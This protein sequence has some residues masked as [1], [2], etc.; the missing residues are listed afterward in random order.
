MLKNKMKNLE[1]FLRFQKTRR[2]RNHVILFL[3]QNVF[4]HRR[5]TVKQLS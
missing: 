2:V 4:F 5:R 1:L 3:N